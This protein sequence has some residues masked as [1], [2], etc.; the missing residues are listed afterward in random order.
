MPKPTP[1]KI[2]LQT[3][4]RMN[5]TQ[6]VYYN[7]KPL[8]LTNDSGA[9]MKEH[10]IAAGY[11]VFT[12]A[13]PRHYRLAIQH[14]E[15]PTSLG[16]V[17][18]DLSPKSLKDE[19]HQ[20]YTPVDAGGGIVLNETGDVLMIYRRGKWD[21][22]KGKRDA[23]EDILQCALREVSEETGLQHLKAG[24]KICD[25]YH[26]YAQNKENL[27]KCTTWYNMTA[28]VKETLVPQKEEN[29]LEARWVTPDSLPSIALKSYEAIREVLV[30]AGLL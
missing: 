23:G 6:K 10:P 21:L 5:F 4:Q 12:G 26:I 17:I 15:K 14:L 2:S 18:E 19:L 7:N 30:Q 28:S 27:L 3:T 20:L 29:I 13:F 24:T 16:V 1:N 9:Y 8:I 25:T 22:P 11:L